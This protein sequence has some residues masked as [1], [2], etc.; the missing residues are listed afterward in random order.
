MSFFTALS[1]SLNNLMTKKT[2]T[3]L[4]SFAG[5]IGIIGIALIL[6]LSSGMQGYINKMQEDT[7]S[8]YPIQIESQSVD[9]SS[10]IGVMMSSNNRD[11]INHDLD[12][13]Y[14]NTVITRM[15]KSMAS[16]VTNNNLR[17]FKKYIEG[18][19]SNQLKEL[20]NSVQ[21][22]YNIDLQIFKSNTE[23]GVLKVNPSEVFDVFDNGQ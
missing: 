1:L 9:M 21:Y 6:S 23:N 13:V 3:I 11:G 22:G 17:E 12:K 5:S 20:T 18:D 8:T 15:A 2:R 14:S 19:V 7:L 16:Q 10:M 4:T